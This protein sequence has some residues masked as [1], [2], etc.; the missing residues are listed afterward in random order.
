MLSSIE[1]NTFSIVEG[2]A[3][4]ILTQNQ[5]NPEFNFKFYSFRPNLFEFIMETV[6]SFD[7]K[8]SMIALL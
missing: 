7:A 6:P 2:V 8:T 4:T 5:S 1:K 3:V